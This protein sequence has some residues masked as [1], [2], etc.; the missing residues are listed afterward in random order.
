MAGCGAG[1][2]TPVVC[3]HHLPRQCQNK[4][5]WRGT[6]CHPPVA[7]TIKP[8][9]RIDGFVKTT[10]DLPEELLIRAK[11]VAAQRRT[12]L[13]ELVVQ[14]LGI[15]TGS[16]DVEQE[17]TGRKATFQKLLQAMKANNTEPMQ[18]LSRE[19]AHER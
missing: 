15:V 6:R 1:T 13:K 9:H 3:L 14:G 7:L 4:F 11:V 2:S 12:T 8:Y 10:I 18:P 5:A 19:Q 17:E 16:Q